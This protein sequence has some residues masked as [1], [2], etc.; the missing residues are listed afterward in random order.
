MCL[1]ICM[2][3]INADFVHVPCDLQDLGRGTGAIL[4]PS[5]QSSGLSAKVSS[6]STDANQTSKFHRMR[7]IS[8]SVDNDNF[9][10]GVG[11]VSCL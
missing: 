1:E 7:L 3:Y 5:P 10:I 8:S 9:D 2:W 6:V 11:Q 4:A